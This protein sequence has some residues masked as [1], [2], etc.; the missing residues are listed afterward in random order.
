MVRD[1]LRRLINQM[2]EQELNEAWFYLRNLHDDHLMLK[3]IEKAKL[4]LRPGDTF[5]KE[6]ALQ[7]MYFSENFWQDQGN[8]G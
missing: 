4:S 6:E 7:F 8:G 3:G 1:K 5:T 2:S